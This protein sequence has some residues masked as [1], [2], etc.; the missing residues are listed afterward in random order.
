MK[1]WSPFDETFLNVRPIGFENYSTLRDDTD[2]LRCVR[3]AGPQASACSQDGED[4]YKDVVL[5]LEAAVVLERHS[6]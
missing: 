6:A 1:A 4:V 2:M 5:F 3:N